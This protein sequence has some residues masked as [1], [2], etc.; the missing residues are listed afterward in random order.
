MFRSHLFLAF[1]GNVIHALSQAAMLVVLAKC[2]TPAMVGEFG[3]GLALTTPIMLFSKLQLRS[4]IVTDAGCEYS[5]A[6]Y[7]RLRLLATVF[8]IV[9]VACWQPSL[10]QA[11]R[12]ESYLLSRWS[13]PSKERVTCAWGFSKNTSI[14]AESRLRHASRG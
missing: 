6:D 4:A 3:L 1:S 13:R 2:G 9:V 7:V 8:A 10:Q 5:F 14:G 12:Y 11:A